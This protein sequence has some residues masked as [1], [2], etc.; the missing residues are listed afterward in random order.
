MTSQQE[1]TIIR[2]HT[3]LTGDITRC[4]RL[5]IFG[6]VEGNIQADFIH[7]HEGGKLFGKVK[8]GAAVIAGEAQGEIKVKNL[9]SILSTGAVSGNVHYGQLALES[10]GDLSADVKNVPPELGGDFH[11]RVAKGKSVPITLTDLSAF[12]PD[13]TADDLTFTISNIK[14]GFVS[15][16]QTPTTPI[17][18]FTQADLEAGKILFVHNG[19]NASKA[20]FDV[21]VADDD[22]AT[23][24]SPQ[25]VEVDVSA[26][27]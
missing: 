9:I 18:K 8:A 12:D 26:S 15:S 5:E 14:N 25:T 27:P 24:G 4:N 7:V 19:A 21:V 3:Q 13:D 17:Q 11:L 22:G 10:G 2:E 6:Y 1:I 20:G 16:T 23:S